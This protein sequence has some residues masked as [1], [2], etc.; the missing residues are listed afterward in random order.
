MLAATT[1]HTLVGSWSGHGGSG[2]RVKLLAGDG[3]LEGPAAGGLSITFGGALIFLGG[4]FAPGVKRSVLQDAS[5]VG[6]MT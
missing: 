6:A 3:F 5:G 2:G 4:I 1:V